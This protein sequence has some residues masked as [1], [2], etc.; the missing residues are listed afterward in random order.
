MNWN[1][2]SHH[3]DYLLEKVKK[4]EMDEQIMPIIHSY[5]GYLLGDRNY[6]E[7]VH[8]KRMTRFGLLCKIKE[9]IFQQI[10][11]P[12]VAPGLG[13]AL[14]NNNLQIP[15]HVIQDFMDDLCKIVY[16]Q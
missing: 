9:D 14:P 6:I 7:E 1:Q 11:G 16:K 3:L 4:N 13:P 10:T 12:A 15:L 8:Q 2:V 5:A